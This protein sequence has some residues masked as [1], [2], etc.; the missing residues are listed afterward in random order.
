MPDEFEI[1]ISKRIDEHGYRWRIGNQTGRHQ[2][3]R[4]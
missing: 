1:V 2:R 3:R 4:G